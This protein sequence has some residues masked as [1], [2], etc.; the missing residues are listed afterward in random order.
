M[1]ILV[2]GGLVR[3]QNNLV[4]VGFKLIVMDNKEFEIERLL[5]IIAIKLRTVDNRKFGKC[6]IFDG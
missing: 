1:A 4:L 5:K 3:I 6:A 2:L